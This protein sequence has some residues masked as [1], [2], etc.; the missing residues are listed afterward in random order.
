MS[1]G[2]AQSIGIRKLAILDSA[3]HKQTY[4]KQC[5]LNFRLLFKYFIFSNNYFL[6]WT[7]KTI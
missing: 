5:Y 3:C 6:L 7:I 4:S 2:S 1:P